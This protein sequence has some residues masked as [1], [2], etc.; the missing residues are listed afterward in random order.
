M[1]LYPWMVWDM[2]AVRVIK[3]DV[4]M[5][6]NQTVEMIAAESGLD[7]SLCHLEINRRYPVTVK[8]KTEFVLLLINILNLL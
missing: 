1:L 4:G 6:Y 3:V 2:I 5:K 7:L 8:G